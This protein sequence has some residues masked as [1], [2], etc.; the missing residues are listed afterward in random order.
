MQPLPEEEII[1]RDDQDPRVSNA[2]LTEGDGLPW[3]IW[4]EPVVLD[5]F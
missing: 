2:S 5:F 1:I 3:L 4:K